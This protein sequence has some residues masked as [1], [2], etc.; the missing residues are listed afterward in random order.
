MRL[1]WRKNILEGILHYDLA[2][3]QTERDRWNFVR[4]VR[5]TLP[6]VIVNGPQRYQV[7]EY[8]GRATR[9]GSFPIS[10]DYESFYQLACS[11]EVA[12]ESWYLHERLPIES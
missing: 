1:P 7:I 3:F 12:E 6:E 5:R 2:G 9:V 8:D 11:S 10:I 4:C